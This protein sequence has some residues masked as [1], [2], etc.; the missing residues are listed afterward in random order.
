MYC[1]KF[2]TIDVYF[3]NSSEKIENWRA[4]SKIEVMAVKMA[5]IDFNMCNFWK[6]VQ[7]N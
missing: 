7:D 5:I 2:F 4:S 6:A 1:S 3:N